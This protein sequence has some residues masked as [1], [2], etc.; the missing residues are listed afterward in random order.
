MKEFV[1]YIQ[2]ENHVK[3]NN[4]IERGYY[5][6]VFIDDI[7]LN[8][9]S[10]ERYYKKQGDRLHEAF[11]D[12]YASWQ[13]SL[14]QDV[15]QPRAVITFMPT[16]R[17]INVLNDQSPQEIETNLADTLEK[18]STVA[19][20]VLTLGVAIDELFIKLRTRAKFIICLLVDT[21]SSLLLYEMHVRLRKLIG[22]IA[23]S[24]FSLYPMYECYPG[25]GGQSLKLIPI[26]LKLS[27]AERI[28]GVR[29]N[30]M[31]MMY[32]KKSECSIMLLG[33]EKAKMTIQ[34]CAPC[35]GNRCLYYQLGGCHLFTPCPG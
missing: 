1:V 25:I 10:L 2:Y 4:D 13:S 12:F 14:C 26:I 31:T 17:L 19:L 21:A 18:S 8:L 23:E 11:T 16:R 15:L 28:I 27:N 33:K 20:T 34:P 22:E 9:D 29:V 7:N 6:K 3:N 24:R 30:E 32:P 5:E 35:Q